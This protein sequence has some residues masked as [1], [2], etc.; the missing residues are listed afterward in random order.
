MPEAVAE[1]VVAPAIPA[2]PVVTPS[3]ARL[4]IEQELAAAFAENPAV[5]QTPVATPTEDAVDPAKP[6]PKPEPVKP[7]EPSLAKRLATLAAAE[8]R[9][10]A[11][12]E[13]R[14]KADAAAKARDDEMRPLLDRL[15]KAKT[16]AT[17]MEAAK[18]ALDLDDEGMAEL[19]LDLQRH[20]EE[21]GT[22]KPKDPTEG[23]A[24]LVKARVADELK[25][26]DEAKKAEDAANLESMRAAHTTRT[27]D[28]LKANRRAYPLV[29]IAPPSQVDITAI[30][31]AWLSA[32]GEIPDPETVLKFIQD[33][34]QANYDAERKA[35]EEE[36]SKSTA[37]ATAAEAGGSKA[38]PRNNDVPITPPRKLSVEDEFL[39]AYKAQHGTA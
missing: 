34:R 29:S 32:N 14:A 31:E 35:A 28:F 4:T 38:K 20:H 3:A 19:F 39:A 9:G 10:K 7:A 8:K 5:E 24:E 33:E 21:A 1:T 11:E 30:S 27:L 12:A 15:T 36:A 17:K 16:A 23:L 13:A 6:E 2:T 25:A 26:R 18:L 22:P 37:A